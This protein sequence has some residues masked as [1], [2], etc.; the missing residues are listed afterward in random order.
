MK[1]IKII[2]DDKLINRLESNELHP[3]RLFFC[4]ECNCNYPR[5]SVKK[6]QGN[7][8]CIHDGK[9][10]VD[11]TDTDTGQQLIAMLGM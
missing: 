4:A 8:F 1:A 7:Y 6:V 2:I 10:V 9:P 3:N 5:N 11:I